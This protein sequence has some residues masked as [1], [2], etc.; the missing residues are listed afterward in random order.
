MMSSSAAA[1][2]MNL[3]AVDGIGDAARD[4]TSPPI[5]ASNVARAAIITPGC[6]SSSAR[7]KNFCT[8][9]CKDHPLS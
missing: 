9:P 5:T 6:R 4:A 1:A 3:N 7:S 2:S 8:S